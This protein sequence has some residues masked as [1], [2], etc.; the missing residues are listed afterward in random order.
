MTR[1][2]RGPMAALA[3]L[4][5]VTLGG[6]MNPQS[7]DEAGNPSRSAAHGRLIEAELPAAVRQAGWDHIGSLMET[8]CTSDP[9]PETASRRTMW[10]GGARELDVD[11]D[12]AR[13]VAQ[14]V[15]DYADSH[16]WTA[17]D[18]QDP[19]GHRLY[20][21]TK[22]E[23]AL[24]VTFRETGTRTALSIVMSSPCL[25]MPAGH[26]MT[27]SEWDPMYGSPDPLYPNDDRSK[28]TNGTPKPLPAPTD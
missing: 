5:A 13:Q 24:Q 1:G 28:F 9:E 20:G 22:D 10:E 21:A 3:A 2:T 23:V 25:D 4:A 7:T 18:D 12:S 11:A 6:C 16:G 26:T 17:T 14:Q 27:R 15:K 19:N 8:S